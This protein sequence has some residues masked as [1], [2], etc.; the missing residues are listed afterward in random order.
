MRKNKWLFL[1]MTLLLIAT[2]SACQDDEA[3]DVNDQE[4]QTEEQ[5][6]GQDV[7]RD[8]DEKVITID[9]KT[10]VYEDLEFYKLMNEIKVDLQVAKDLEEL[11]ADKQEDR[12]AYAEEELEY[13]ENVNVNLQS[14][15]ELYAMSALAAEKNYFVPDEKLE[16]LVAEFTEK[17]KENE[18]ANERLEAY[19]EQEYNQNIR[20]YIR[21]TALR[22]RIA[23][24]LREE[25][26]EEHP[27]ASEAEISYLLEEKFEALYSDQLVSLELDI[28]LK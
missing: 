18:A 7:E 6:E 22:D 5:S 24:E 28:H 19:G 8:R 15:I 21:Q 10:F 14:L 26:E 1:V 17:V 23:G 11:A 2:M 4:E 20:E 9:D 16:N 13:Y 27:D 12:K 25:L 3:E